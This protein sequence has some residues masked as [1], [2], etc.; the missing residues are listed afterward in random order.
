[1]LSSS[2]SPWTCLSDT[3][4]AIVLAL[5]SHGRL[6][7][8]DLMALVGISPG[9]VTRLTTPM[10]NAGLL[11]TSTEQVAGTGRPQSP[12]SLRAEA[13]SL[14]GATVTGTTLTTV[15]TDLRL[16][17]LATARQPL[18]SHRP[19]EVVAQ[20]AQTV[21]VLTSRAPTPPTAMA[22]SLGGTSSDTRAVDQAVFLGWHGVRLADMLEQATGLPTTVGN[23]VAA[24]TQQEAWFGAGR[25]AERFALVTVGVGVGH[26]LAINREAVSTADAD[27]GLIGLVP[28]PDDA[29]PPHARPA[30][31]CLTD[32]ALEE[33]WLQAGGSA[34]SA[35]SILEQAQAGHPRAVSVCA[36]F[37]RRLGRLIAMSA[38]FTLPDLV[39]IAGERATVASLFEDQ[40][41]LGIAQTRHASARPIPLTVREHDRSDWARGA[42][43]LAVRARV[44]GEL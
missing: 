36:A 28:V 42:A 8:P 24:M 26:G 25:E 14:I 29:R 11:T 3:Q 43:A 9:S 31:D 39:V 21:S 33:D 2:P 19:E 6:S 1:M 10:I 12:L 37:A 40:V 41:M 7:R 20:L 27:L 5:L 34:T 18:A 17:V 38:A 44:R 13:E 30:M 16:Q 4:R 23:D 32:T 35:S 15:L 22:V